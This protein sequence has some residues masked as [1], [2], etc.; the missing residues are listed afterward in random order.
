MNR[1][2]SVFCF[3][4]TVCG[5][6]CQTWICAK[7]FTNPHTLLVS[8]WEFQ[9]F[10]GTALC[11]TGLY[12]QYGMRP[13]QRETEMKGQRQR[14]YERRWPERWRWCDTD[15]SSGTAGPPRESTTLRTRPPKLTANH[16]SLC[17]PL[18]G[19]MWCIWQ[20]NITLKTWSLSQLS[21]SQTHSSR[22]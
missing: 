6:A 12:D 14:R 11:Y 10:S 21:L 5:W 2:V 20:Y 22:A 15:G 16:L 7:V 9:G 3:V 4:C 18:W 1:Y 17:W 19:L 8:P 13:R